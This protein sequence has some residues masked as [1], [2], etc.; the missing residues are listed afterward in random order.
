[1]LQF[2]PFACACMSVIFVLSLSL[3]FFVLCQVPFLFVSAILLA[4]GGLPLLGQSNSAGWDVDLNKYT[5]APFPSL[6]LVFPPFFILFPYLLTLSSNKFLPDCK[7][8]ERNPP[9]PP[10]ACQEKA[11]LFSF[12]PASSHTPRVIRHPAQLVVKAFLPLFFLPRR[13]RTGR[14]RRRLHVMMVSSNTNGRKTQ[15]RLPVPCS[16]L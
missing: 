12:C 16:L 2:V 5:P 13:L 7:S 6:C 4:L 3:L 9:D 15:S 1:M 8:K 14:R 11:S 10:S